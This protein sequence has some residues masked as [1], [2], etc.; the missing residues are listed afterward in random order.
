M[1]TALCGVT[2]IDGTGADPRTGMTLVM[3]DRRLAVVGTGRPPAGARVIDV[4]GRVVIPG[5]FNC[6]VHLQLD[7]GPSPLVDLATEPSGMSLLRAARR[8][9]QMLRA[10][11]TAVRDCGAK[12]WHI[13]HLRDAVEGGVVEGPRILACGRALCA[14]GGH[15]EVVGEPVRG[16]DEVAG[17]VRRQLDAGADFIKAMATGGFGRAGERLDHSELGVEHLRVAA[18]TAHAAGRRLTVHAYGAGGIRDAAR[19]GADSVEHA[20]FVDD[21]ALD[22]LRSRGVFTV[23]TLTNTFRVV[24]EGAKG[25]VPSH[26]VASA[27]AAWPTMLANAART[28]R[29]GVKMAVGTDAGS[30][31]NPH[32]DI[33]T[34]LRLRVQIGATPLEALTM[35]TRGSAECLGIAKDVGTLEPGKLA[36]LVVLDADPL[37]DMGALERIHAVFKGGRR[38]GPGAE[39]Q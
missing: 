12:D 22:L 14:A 4:E 9:G 6:H 16:V 28:W 10:G 34:E 11:V 8:A 33:A 30:W 36:D 7:G 19:G 37:V 23:P 29:A 2:L 35:A 3:D 20:A 27:T 25:G 21:E 39:P 31:L 13:I 24:T 26:V 18:Q 15:A 38:V 5:L 32:A 17:A 1:T